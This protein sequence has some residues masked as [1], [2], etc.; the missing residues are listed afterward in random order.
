MYTIALCIEFCT[1]SPETVAM[2]VSGLRGLLEA[3]LRR[4][5]LPLRMDWSAAPADYIA[6]HN[7]ALVAISQRIR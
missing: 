7:A 5:L 6:A 2:Q 1:L 3:E 4:H